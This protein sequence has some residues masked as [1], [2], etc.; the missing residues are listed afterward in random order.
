MFD[1]SKVVEYT[2]DLIVCFR[3]RKD[4]F[5]PISF[6]GGVSIFFQLMMLEIPSYKHI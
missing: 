5:H 6:W 1:F 4:K 3:T 2:Y